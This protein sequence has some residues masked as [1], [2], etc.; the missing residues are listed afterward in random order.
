MKQPSIYQSPAHVARDTA[1]MSDSELRH[2]Y[3]QDEVYV[4]AVGWFYI[5]FGSLMLGLSLLALALALLAS[6][7]AFACASFST[8]MVSITYVV[9]G[10]GMRHLDPWSRRPAYL[11]AI[12][13]MVLFPIGTLAGLI[14]FYLLKERSHKE[15]FSHKYRGLLLS[16]DAGAL[17]Q[18]TWI[19]M[20]M[21]VIT[22]VALAVAI[23]LIQPVLSLPAWLTR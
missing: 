13:M 4:R 1:T 17:Y 21:G 12:V 6:K 5:Y 10:W 14:C 23:Y 16:D 9:L 3:A 20:L 19:P 15:I 8:L 22:A 7:L 11:A 2:Y 18:A